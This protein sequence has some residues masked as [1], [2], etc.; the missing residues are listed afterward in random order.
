ML[1]VLAFALQA[2]PAGA[3]N[4]PRVVASTLPLHGI[5]S[6]LMEGR[7]KV[8]LLLS[9][10]ASPH[11][12]SLR[13]S[14]ARSI[15]EA[16]LLVWVG[17]EM[18][19]GLSK[20]M[21]PLASAGRLATLIEIPVLTL[22][23][24]RSGGL[25]AQP[26]DHDPHGHDAEPHAEQ[27]VEKDKDHPQPQSEAGHEHGAIDPHIWLDPQNGRLIA[28]HLAQRLEQMDPEFAPL[29]RRNAETFAGRLS[30]LE[31]RIAAQLAPLA[32]QPYLVTHDAF[33]YFE[34]RFGLAA[35]GSLA[36]SPEHPPGARRILEIRQ[37][38]LDGGIHC[39]FAEP[40]FQPKVLETLLAGTD[41]RQG[42][43]DAIGADLIPGPDAY[44]ELLEGMAADFA[45]CLAP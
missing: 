21:V 32:E 37:L 18:E 25:W 1:L 40:Q 17:P 27:A 7:G 2:T 30:A 6:A 33:Q 45:A 3:Q 41:V 26:S 43:L 44:L 38:L 5:A 24:P 16:D 35:R 10:T 15:D 20:I 23:E 34:R 8:E 22:L 4:P 11:D 36:V 12:F 13:P 39:V 28:M 29:Y 42:R 31:K 14:Q 19:S 9:A